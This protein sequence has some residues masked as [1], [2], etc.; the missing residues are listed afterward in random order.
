PLSVAHSTLPTAERPALLASGGGR[1]MRVHDVRT[2]ACLSRA[3]ARSKIIVCSLWRVKT[4][5]SNK[6]H[7]NTNYTPRRV[8]S[9]AAAAAAAAA[10]A[11]TKQDDITSTT[12]SKKRR[13]QKKNVNL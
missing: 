7:R 9:R 12:R 2:N 4:R 8:S 13:V 6:S 5:V 11:T 3:G 1:E 10:A